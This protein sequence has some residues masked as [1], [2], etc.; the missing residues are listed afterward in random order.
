MWDQ[1]KKLPFDTLSIFKQQLSYHNRL[2]VKISKQAVTAKA[3]QRFKVMAEVVID[4]P[5]TKMR[6]IALNTVA[7][8]LVDVVGKT[9]EAVKAS[10]WVLRAESDFY[11]LNPLHLAIKYGL[12]D[13]AKVLLSEGVNV[14][15]LDHIGRPALHMVVL[16][17][18]E[19]IAAKIG[20]TLV[21]L[22]GPY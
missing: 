3:P 22:S 9:F 15:A 17:D 2:S 10:G 7:M 1:M 16:L 8:D 12:F 19:L 5:A 6:I 18:D 14:N 13:C 21:V 11:V 20:S 4:E